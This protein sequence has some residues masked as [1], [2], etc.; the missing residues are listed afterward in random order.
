MAKNNIMFIDMTIPD[1]QGARRVYTEDSSTIVVKHPGWAFEDSADEH[2]DLF[3]ICGQDFDSAKN[4]QLL[5]TWKPAAATTGGVRW[6]ASL[7]E[8]TDSSTDIDA[9]DWTS[10][11]TAATGA[12]S[13]APTPLGECIT[14][15]LT[16]SSHG[17]AAGDKF[18]CRLYRDV[19]HAGDT[20]FGDAYILYPRFQE[21]S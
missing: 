8:I 15:T 13:S 12:T 4:V 19:S 2:M 1:T 9:L 11:Y 6:E 10:G 14:A 18:H 21:A 3:M 5:V 16:F 17:L 7:I 20:M